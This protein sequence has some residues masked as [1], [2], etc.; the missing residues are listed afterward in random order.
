MF[1]APETS[2]GGRLREEVV[3]DVDKSSVF[4]DIWQQAATVIVILRSSWNV[5]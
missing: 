2:I 3:S 4:S 1:Q 5:D